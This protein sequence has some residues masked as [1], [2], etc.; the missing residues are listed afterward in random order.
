MQQ[1]EEYVC[2]SETPRQNLVC[3]PG[4][5]RESKKRHAVLAQNPHDTADLTI[6]HIEIYNGCNFIRG[7]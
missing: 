7:S 1:F 5:C 2:Q 3:P 6:K 4:S